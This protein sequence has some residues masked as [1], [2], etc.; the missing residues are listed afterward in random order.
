MLRFLPCLS[1]IPS[2]DPCTMPFW[3]PFGRKRRK[4]KKNKEAK[5]A[6]TE[7][8]VISEKGPITPQKAQPGSAPETRRTSNYRADTHDSSRTASR[9]VSHQGS[10]EKVGPSP[11]TAHS[12]IRTPVRERSAEDIT[13]LPVNKLLEQS[14]H[15][16]PARVFCMFTHP[17]NRVTMR[18]LSLATPQSPT[19]TQSKR[20][21]TDQGPTRSRS[22]KK[23]KDVH[24]RQ[25][26]G[27]AASSPIPIPKRPGTESGGLLRRESKRLRGDL[28]DESVISLPTAA[29][30]RSSVSV[31]SDNH[32]EVGSVD[33]F[34]PRPTIRYSLQSQFVSGALRSAAQS[35]TDSRWERSTPTRSVLRESKTIDQLADDFDAGTL[36]DLMER[37]QRRRERKR[38]AEE[39]R[40]RRRLERHAAKAEAASSSK[41]VGRSRSR[42][43]DR[44]EQPGRNAEGLGLTGVEAGPSSPTLARQRSGDVHDEKEPIK[45]TEDLSQPDPFKETAS[46]R[47]SPVEEPVVEQAREVRYSQA[48]VSPPASPLRQHT[49]K[50]S[51]L[52]QAADPRSASV[53]NVAET[54]VDPSRRASD[55]GTRRGSTLA[56]LFRRSAPSVK[57]AFD[58]RG[59][60]PSEMSFS[61]T[62]RESMRGQLPPAHLRERP[63]PVRARSGTPTRTKSK[64]REDL[65]ELPI[66]PPDSRVQSPEA[67]EQ[68]AALSARQRSKLPEGSR[69][70]TELRESREEHRDSM[71]SNPPLSAAAT[72]SQSLAS[73]DSEG[74][75]LSSGRPRK[76][77]SQQMT[78][79]AGTGEEQQGEPF[80]SD[81][82]TKTDQPESRLSSL[83][84]A[85]STHEEDEDQTGPG[86]EEGD[87][88]VVRGEVAR[89][90]TVV[91]NQG[92]ARSREGLL[93]Q[94]NEDKGE[95]Q[96]AAAVA[97]EHSPASQESLGEQ[98]SPT[99]TE[100]ARHARHLSSGSAKLLDIPA[101]R[102]SV[103]SQSSTPPP[104]ASHSQ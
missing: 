57:R 22:N 62:S 94:F 45:T 39:D 93:R 96:T 24:E 44:G 63:P 77:T 50:P 104:P 26:Q 7:P 92:R 3:W 31:M 67:P 80:R 73:V 66:S 2:R 13:A 38:K 60:A 19:S 23:R 18:S 4:N 79:G 98:H 65:P 15:L 32:F 10:K 51:N 82:P 55:T 81:S 28:R 61:N 37:D 84:A 30:V 43:R 97:E 12:P 91:H 29:S 102:A 101:R 68:P 69:L 72:L 14:P 35:R 89:Q 90:P 8:S 21:A 16:R 75:W 86:Q 71:G 78:T 5:R 27:N 6:A 59:R 87:E 83:R 17:T 46:E 58:D 9:I 33:V 95:E 85:L 88:R 49:R 56:S 20:S 53:T 54:I 74:S 42:R 1:I 99:I 34:S 48:S 25:L 76:R 70:N 52:S 100:E 41:P 103:M 40:A 11:R 64:F 36:K 47:A